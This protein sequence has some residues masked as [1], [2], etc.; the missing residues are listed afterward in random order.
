MLLIASLCKWICGGV[1]F[2]EQSWTESLF[3]LVLVPG[4]LIV[5]LSG[6]GK[7]YGMIGFGGKSAQ[8]ATIAYVTS[9][10][11]IVLFLIY[12]PTM[13]VKWWSF[14]TPVI[15]ISLP[16]ACWI[17]SRLWLLQLQLPAAGALAFWTCQTWFAL[18]N[19]QT[20]GYGM[21]LWK[22]WIS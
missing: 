3:L 11:L 18:A 20:S 2:F 15:F 14:H 7:V 5:F 16:I 6:A 12:D 21:G 1:S 13:D 10:V 17:S 19:I 8:H 22:G 4:G 9:L